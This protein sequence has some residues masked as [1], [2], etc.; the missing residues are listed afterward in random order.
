M[1][2]L[3]IPSVDSI[4]EGEGMESTADANTEEKAA[5]ADDVTEETSDAAAEVTELTSEPA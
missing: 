1:E 4:C 5:A 2:E 3:S